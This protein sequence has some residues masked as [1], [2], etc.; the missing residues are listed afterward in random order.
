MSWI[1]LV[2][3][4]A[5]L[6]VL[7]TFCMKTMRPLRIVALG[8][9]VLFAIYGFF[10][11]LYPVL[12]L[13]VVLFPINIARLVQLQ[14]LTRRV[15]A[16]ATGDLSM[17]DLMP[18]MHHRKVRAG[19]TVFRK[20]DVADGLHYIDSGRV[21]I[22]ELGISRSSGEV[23]GEIGLFAP[24]RRRTATIVAATD[25]DLYDLSEAK[26]RELYFQNPGFGFAVLRLITM[27]LLENARGSSEDRQSGAAQPGSDADSPTPDKRMLSGRAQT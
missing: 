16:A 7:A 9:N 4:A 11:G 13:H 23:F 12:I 21:E 8:S 20:G 14:N 19:E 17:A 27:R 3:Y 6:A 25:C 24:D 5:S 15:A 2:G 1:T 22:M 18:F 10:G 26:A